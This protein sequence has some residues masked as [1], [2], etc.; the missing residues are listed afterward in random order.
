MY[1]WLSYESQRRDVHTC[2]ELLRP[3]INQIHG[4]RKSLCVYQ[5]KQENLQ[6]VQKQNPKT[7]NECILA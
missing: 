7:F 5:G 4:L 2:D 6:T 3:S 1:P